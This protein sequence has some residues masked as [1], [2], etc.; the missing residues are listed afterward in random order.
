MPEK[1][2]KEKTSSYTIE[3]PR[4]VAIQAKINAM[5]ADKHLYQYFV[6][7]ITEKTAHDQQNQE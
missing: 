2:P 3:L 7:A 5:K 4:K 6:D 1:T